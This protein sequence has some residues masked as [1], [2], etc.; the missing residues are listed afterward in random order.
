MA[1]YMTTSKG[2][3]EFGSWLIH[4]RQPFRESVESLQHA[5][6]AENNDEHQKQVAQAKER[7]DVDDYEPERE[8]A[9]GRC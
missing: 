2:S 7:A 6:H 8:D 5:V 4:Y 3:Q 9:C 1:T